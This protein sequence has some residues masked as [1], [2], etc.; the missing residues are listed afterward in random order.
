MSYLPSPADRGATKAI[1]PQ[2]NKPE[3]TLAPDPEGPLAVLVFKTLADPF[4]GPASP[5][6]ASSPG[7]SARI[8]TSWNA[9]K[10]KEERIGDDHDPAAGEE[11]GERP[12]PSRVRGTS[13][14]WPSGDHHHGGHS[15][16]R[17]LSVSSPP[18][19]DRLPGSRL[20]CPAGWRPCCAAPNEDK[21][22]PALQRMHAQS[23]PPTIRVRARPRDGPDR[24]L[25]DG[26]AT[27]RSPWSGSSASSAGPLRI[28]PLRVPYRRR[29]PPAIHGE[30]GRASFVRQTGGHGQRQWRL[31]LPPARSP[32]P[33]AAAHVFAD[34][35]VGG[36][37]S[38]SFRPAVDNGIRGERWSK[39]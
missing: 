12:P 30:G 27:S 11:P 16:R 20:R 9:S 36:V 24:R 26:T 2:G 31:L 1:S 13:P 6:S 3:A 17:R 37:V 39:A 10:E 18:G 15:P 32:S 29:F 33:P 7:R 25:R 28:E 8:A 4:I 21:M 35:I 23:R 22:G 5:S 38:H 19:A 14:R 34:K